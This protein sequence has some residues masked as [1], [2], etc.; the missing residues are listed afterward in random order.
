MYKCIYE[1]EC[2]CSTVLIYLGLKTYNNAHYNNWKTAT[3]TNPFYD[4][5]NKTS[6]TR[7]EQWTKCYHIRA[8]I[9]TNMSL[10]AFI[11]YSSIFI[12]REKLIRGVDTCVHMLLKVARDKAFNRLLKW[13]R[14]N[15]TQITVINKSHNTSLKLSTTVLLTS[16]DT[17]W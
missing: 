17:Q 11:I 7:K 16:S 5:F 6:I 1:R 2:K 9:N 13:K 14:K 15:N 12:W 4:Y 10:E 8:G 3:T